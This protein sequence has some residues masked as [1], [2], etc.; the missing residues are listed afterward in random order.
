MFSL[1]NQPLRTFRL[2]LA[3]CISLL[4]ALPLTALAGTAQA[5]LQSFIQDVETFQANF[6]QTLY[7]ADSQ[8]LKESV[9]SIQLKRPG[10]FVWTYTAPEVQ[11]IVGDGQRIWL[12]D[13]DLAQVTVNSMDDRVAGTPLVL[14]MRSA[15]LEE[16]FDVVELGEAEGINWLELTPKADSSDFEQVYIGLNE[17]GLVAME[18]R[19]NFG[20]ATQI[21]FS[22][23]EAGIPL[24]DEL[25]QFT[26]PDG[27]DVIGLDE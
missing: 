10:R 22:N 6:E 2:W 12:Y 16:T 15:P 23:F 26:V 17:D 5:Q 11:Q 21:R 20:Q 7:D 4:M 8:P 19:D 14:L 13:Q 9:G 18:L 27:V 24:K 1:S 25:F 3:L